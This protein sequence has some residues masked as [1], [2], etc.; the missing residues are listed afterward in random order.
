MVA[1]DVASRA[2]HVARLRDDFELR[3]GVQ[4]HPQPM[5]HDHVVVGQDDPDLLLGHRVWTLASAL[6]APFVAHEQLHIERH[7]AEARERRRGKRARRLSVLP[8]GDRRPY[9]EGSAG[10]AI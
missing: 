7:R 9:P 1:V 5:A 8:R 6:R 3:L 2:V 4:Q 10:M